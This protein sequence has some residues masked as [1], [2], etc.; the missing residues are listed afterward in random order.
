MG[1][2]V[3]SLPY[4]EKLTL[5]EGG[6]RRQDSVYQGLRRLSDEIEIV[7]VHD[8][9]RPFVSPA[10]IERVIEGTRKNEACIPALG[11]RET[12][13]EVRQGRVVQTLDHRHLLLAQTPQGFRAGLLKR[14]FECAVKEDF[15]GTDEAMLVERLGFPVHV[16]EGEE[17]NR[18]ITY[19]E[20]LGPG[21]A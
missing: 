8:A 15:Y 16:V 6:P 20:D 5:E 3:R 13:K 12:V 19:Q 21:Y 1:N 4:R 7:L 10:L 9:A 2:Q 18:K 17:G 14:A 11:V